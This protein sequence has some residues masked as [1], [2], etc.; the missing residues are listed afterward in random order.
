MKKQ[1]YTMEEKIA[2]V[3]AARKKVERILDDGLDAI[4]D[5]P[6]A[7]TSDY[8]HSKSLEQAQISIFLD[9]LQLHESLKDICNLEYASAV[10]NVLS[11]DET[12]LAKMRHDKY[13]AMNNTKVCE[14]LVSMA[15]DLLTVDEMLDALSNV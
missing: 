3:K 4:L 9:T 6:L 2:L 15:I 11:V 8:L 10:S 14:I 7:N 1:N 5:N 12:E 13:A